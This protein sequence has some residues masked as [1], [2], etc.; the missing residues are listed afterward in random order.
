MTSESEPEVVQPKKFERKQHL[1][2]Q[3]H[4]L[5]H[6]LQQLQEQQAQL[7]HKYYS[8]RESLSR[9][10]ST[11]SIFTANSNTMQPA[12]M[13]NQPTTSSSTQALNAVNVT[14]LGNRFVALLHVTVSLVHSTHCTNRWNARSTSTSGETECRKCGAT[15]V[16]TN[17]VKPFEPTSSHSWNPKMYKYLPAK[18]L[19]DIPAAG[20]TEPKSPSLA[21]SF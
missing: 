11:N 15:P 7:E 12:H 20:K 14:S 5:Q 9:S 6:Q 1:I 21:I 2:E 16:K 18:Y 10:S 8:L 3:H 4:I 17:L 13:I 19:K